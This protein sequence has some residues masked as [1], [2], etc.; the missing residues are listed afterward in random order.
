M[1][2]PLDEKGYDA[3]T[4]ALLNA[5][6][7][8]DKIA[9]MYAEVAIRAYLAASHVNETPETE[10]VEG[11]VLSSAPSEMDVVAWLD[12]TADAAPG[13]KGVTTD[14]YAAAYWEHTSGAPMT[15][16]VRASQV[17]SAL[18]AMRAERDEAIGWPNRSDITH[19]CTDCEMV[20]VLH[21]GRCGC[22]SGRVVSIASMWQRAEAAEARIK[23]LEEA[24]RPFAAVADALPEDQFANSYTPTGKDVLPSMRSFRAARSALK[25]N[26]L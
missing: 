4:Q 7:M 24:L 18:A 26:A 8:A 12:E 13:A 1:T 6:P 20:A 23:A 3:S 2:A 15:E 10:H 21:E 5:F 9:A 22:G 11:D 25:E 19:Y 16:L 14:A 17:Q